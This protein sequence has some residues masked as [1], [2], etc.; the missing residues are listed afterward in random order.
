MAVVNARDEILVLDV[1]GDNL[2]RMVFSDAKNLSEIKNLDLVQVNKK[3]NGLPVYKII[4]QGKWQYQNKKNKRQNKSNTHQVKEVRFRVRTDS[5]DMKIKIGQIKKF[6][7][8]GF[9]VKVAVNMR[10]GRERSY[11]EIAES[12][13]AEIMESIKDM[14]KV[15]HQ[16]KSSGGVFIVVRPFS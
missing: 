4:D 12:K 5:H 10:K 2:G 13:L 8:K 9:D 6:I 7:T 16:E 3:N 1:N 14:V 11:P 15:N